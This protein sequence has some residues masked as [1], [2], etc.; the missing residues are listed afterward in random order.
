MILRHS[1]LYCVG[2]KVVI[3]IFYIYLHTYCSVLLP[4]P[5]EGGQLDVGSHGLEVQGA[6]YTHAL[7]YI[8]R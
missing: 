6:L 3:G 4:S 2:R 1:K 7:N 5:I 8:D